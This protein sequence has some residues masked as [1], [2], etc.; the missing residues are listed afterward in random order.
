MV[1]S[2]NWHESHRMV[3]GSAWYECELC[4]CCTLE[5]KEEGM[6][7]RLLERCPQIDEYLKREQE[8][9]ELAERQEYEQL[10]ERNNREIYLIRKYGEFSR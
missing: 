2:D 7:R 8:M 9:A 3:D 4:G 1:L 6:R 5:F 10:I